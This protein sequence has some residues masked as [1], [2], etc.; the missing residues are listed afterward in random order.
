LFVYLNDVFLIAAALCARKLE[1]SFMNYGV[2]V[3]SSDGI[4]RAFGLWLI[5]SGDVVKFANNCKGLALNLER[6]LVGIVILGNPTSIPEGMLIFSTKS[7]LKIPAGTCSLGSVVDSLGNV[8]GTSSLGRSSLH[9]EALLLEAPAP[10]ILSRSPVSQPLY[11]GLKTLDSMVPIGRGQ[12]ELI[13]GDRQTGKTTVVLD[14]IMF[15]KSSKKLSPCDALFSVFVSIGQKRASVVQI[16]RGLLAKK[17]IEFTTLVSAT[18]SDSAAL[19]Y[20]APYSGV[21]FAE[22]FRNNALHSLVVYDDLSKQAIA[23]RQMSLVLR[24]P[25]G[26]EAYPGDVFYLHSRLLER[27]AKLGADYGGGSLTA[28]PVVETQAGD[29]SA[30]IPT[31][32][33]SITDGQIFLEFYLFTRGIRPAVNVG[34]SVSRIG[35]A[36]QSKLLKG[37]SSS[38]KLELA[39]Y[40]EVEAFAQFG[41]DLDKTT[42]SVL[43][44]GARLVELLRQSKHNPYPTG[45]Q[46]PL[47]F[48][49]KYLF[50]EN[51]KLS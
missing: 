16:A 47:L 38:L 43:N 10:G 40:R 50:L 24:R 36:A 20:L 25:P 5:R 44:R 17:A 21:A 18:A 3:A 19:Q 1:K 4:V 45:L 48:A 37:V 29:V 39:Q 26:R 9:A 28:L 6:R 46:V 30:Y 7:L 31:N 11:T 27:S 22:W 41:A 49:G 13:I 14:I 8:L 15:N 51:L 23:Y 34:L 12:R 35:S 33:I 2:V 42:M 32:V